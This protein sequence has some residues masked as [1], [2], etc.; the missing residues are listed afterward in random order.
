MDEAVAWAGCVVAGS[1]G[2]LA[3]G[4]VVVRWAGRRRV[5]LHRG[6][7]GAMRRWPGGRAERCE[8]TRDR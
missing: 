5:A 3:A 2:G 7:G 8:R 6:R 1:A 4:L